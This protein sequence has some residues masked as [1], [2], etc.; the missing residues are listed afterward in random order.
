MN[1]CYKILNTEHCGPMTHLQNRVWREDMNK[2]E[3]L[4]VDLGGT[5]WEKKTE[6]DVKDDLVMLDYVESQIRSQ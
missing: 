2:D 1:L 6:L 3:T 5:A 4:F